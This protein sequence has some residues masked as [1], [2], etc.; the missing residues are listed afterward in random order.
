MEFT[1]EQEELNEM[2][3]RNP[4][5]RELFETKYCREAKSTDI[6]DYQN[7]KYLGSF[8]LELLEFFLLKIKEKGIL[9]I[10]KQAGIF[11][12]SNGK[13]API[14]SHFTETD[15]LC[16]T[17]RENSRESMI[18]DIEQIR[19]KQYFENL[20]IPNQIYS[21]SQSFEESLIADKRE[22]KALQIGK[23]T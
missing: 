19:I 2:L 5:I 23:D 13:L 11:L 20:D 10:N 14:I 1:K 17:P 6:R 12:D 8:N 9:P 15:I 7:W 21:A 18:M 3:G 22:S 4:L 16:L